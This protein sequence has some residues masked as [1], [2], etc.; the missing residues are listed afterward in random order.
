MGLPLM[1]TPEAPET[2]DPPQ[3]VLSPWTAAGLPFDEHVG[4]AFKDGSGAAGRVAGARRL[5]AL[6]HNV[7]AARGYSARR[8]GVVFCQRGKGSKRKSTTAS[9][10]SEVTK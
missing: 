3:P 9:D 1:N 10:F 8:A 7:A 5:L 6:D 2:I 4:R